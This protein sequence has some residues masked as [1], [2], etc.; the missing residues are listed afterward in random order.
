MQ[1]GLP[2]VTQKKHAITKVLVCP[3]QT[4][5]L[6]LLSLK[7]LL[8]RDPEL[9]DLYKAL[10][11]GK[12][13]SEGDFWVGE[14]EQRLLEEYARKQQKKGLSSVDLVDG[15]DSGDATSEEIT[16][17]ISK[18]A[19]ERIFI[20]FPGVLRVYENQVQTGKMDETQFWT[21]YLQS[22]V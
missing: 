2:A 13:V 4:N 19:M 9:A 15:K 22:K 10:V 20:E 6:L 7:D 12:I 3:P 11:V 16:H 8:L 21:A 17:E 5:K 1:R 14:R 18:E